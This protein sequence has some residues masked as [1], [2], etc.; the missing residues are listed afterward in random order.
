MPA[1]DPSRIRNVAVIG[2]R[3][4]GKTS[5]TEAIL[6][7]SGAVNRQGTVEQGTTVADHDEDEK[8][9]QMSISASLCHLKWRDRN[10]NLM[11]TPGDPSFHADTIAALR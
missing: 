7:I 3:G 6:F 5:L 10:I 2:H 1:A 9:R 4:T 11:D 8:K